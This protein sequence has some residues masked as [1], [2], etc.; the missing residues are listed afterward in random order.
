MRTPEEYDKIFKPIALMREN[1]DLVAY[2]AAETVTEVLQETMVGYAMIVGTLDSLTVYGLY[3][4]GQYE[5]QTEAERE[6]IENIERTLQAAESAT[7]RDATIKRFQVKVALGA[8]IESD[9]ES[10]NLHDPQNDRDQDH[11][12][13]SGL[14]TLG[15]AEAGKKIVERELENAKRQFEAMRAAAGPDPVLVPGGRV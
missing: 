10:L 9:P 4:L 15:G 12:N 11:K 14:I 1:F 3:K 5:P 6:A 13:A 7:E 2:Q 8:D